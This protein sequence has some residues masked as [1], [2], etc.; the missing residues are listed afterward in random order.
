[1]A[2]I[3]AYLPPAR[4]ATSP[5]CA[6]FKSYKDRENQHSGE[7]CQMVDKKIAHSV[8]ICAIFKTVSTVLITQQ[9]I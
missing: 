1:M 3:L 2:G 9:T 8:R 7:I 4:Y 5:C 6:A